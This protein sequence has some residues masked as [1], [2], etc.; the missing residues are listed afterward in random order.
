MV[1]HQAIEMSTQEVYLGHVFS[2]KYYV[3]SPTKTILTTN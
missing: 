1:L 3:R 2:R